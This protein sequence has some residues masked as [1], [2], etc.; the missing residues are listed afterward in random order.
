MKTRRLQGMASLLAVFAAVVVLA[1]CC[2]VRHHDGWRHDRWRGPE[3][4]RCE[5][6]AIHHGENCPMKHRR[7]EWR[8]ERERRECCGA[9]MWRDGERG[10][11][12]RPMLHE[13]PG[14]PMMHEGKGAPA[15]GLSDKCQCPTCKCGEACP[16]HKGEICPMKGDGKPAPPAPPAK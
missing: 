4:G 6:G 14:R 16:M 13:G 3:Y 11:G 12:E 2:T 5:C 8:M 7:P 15:A 10:R 1:G 9:P